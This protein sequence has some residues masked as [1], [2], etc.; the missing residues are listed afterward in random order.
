MP[1]VR[2]TI[3]PDQEVEVDDRE[4]ENLKQ[5]LLLVEDDEDEGEPEPEPEQDKKQ[6]QRLSEPEAKSPAKS[7]AKSEGS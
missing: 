2:L 4:F 3:R 6:D 7:Q 1:T 5:Q